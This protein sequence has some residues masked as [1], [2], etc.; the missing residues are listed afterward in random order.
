M[1][2]MRIIEVDGKKVLVH[3]E[4]G[5]VTNIDAPDAPPDEPRQAHFD[6]CVAK[7]REAGLLSGSVPILAPTDARAT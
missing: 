7:I 5:V 2:S 6:Y 4:N 1:F 3:E